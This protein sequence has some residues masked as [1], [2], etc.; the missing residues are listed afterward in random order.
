MCQPKRLSS[1][2]RT[3]RIWKV[4]FDKSYFHLDVDYQRQFHL[5]LRWHILACPDNVMSRIEDIKPYTS[6]L[7]IVKQFWIKMLMLL[8]ISYDNSPD[9]NCGVGIWIEHSDKVIIHNQNR[10]GLNSKDNVFYYHASLCWLSLQFYALVNYWNSHPLEPTQ[11]RGFDNPPNPPILKDPKLYGWHNTLCIT[12]ND[13][14]SC[15]K[16]L[17]LFKFLFPLQHIKRPPLRPG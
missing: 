8:L 1:R 7:I 4:S 16:T 14:I 11:I 15:Y 9:R 2:I 10:K 5:S 17:Q 12:Q 3:N 6:E 13:G